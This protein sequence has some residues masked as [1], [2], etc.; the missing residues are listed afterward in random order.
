MSIIS[1]IKIGGRLALGFGIVLLCAGALLALGLWRMSDLQRN[2]EVMVKDTGGGLVDAVEM[3]ETGWAVMQ[4][5]RK[6]MTPTDAMEAERESKRLDELF[7]AYAGW[8][9]DLRKVVTSAEGKA[10]LAATEDD[11]KALVPLVAKLKAMAAEGDYIEGGQMMKNE[12]APL[13]EKWMISLGK[14]ARR[15]QAEM[16]A[17]YDVSLQNYRQTRAGMLGVGMLTLALGAAVAWFITRTIIGPLRHASRIADVIAGGDLTEKIEATSRDE[18]GQLVGSLKTMQ[19]NLVGT[20]NRIKQGTEVISVAAHQIASGNADLSARTE[21]QAGSLEETAA[22]MEELTATVRKNA[23]NAQQANQLVAAAAGLALKG[24]KVVGRVVDTMASI[25]ES[26]RKIVDIIGVIDGI[27]FQTNILALNAAVEAARAG[28]QGR[29]FAVV[30][31]EVRNLAQRSAGAAREIK[32]LIGDSVEKVDLG[33]G[34]VDE[35]GK[36]M[37][38]IVASVQDVT[39]IMGKIAA[40]SEEQSGGI[41]EVNQAIARI[42]DMTQ[43]NA[44]LVEQAAAAAMSMQHQTE[45]L[46]QAVS[47]FRL[48]GSAEAEMAVHEQVPAVMALLGKPMSG[49]LL[50][51]P[52]S[53]A[54]RLGFLQR[55]G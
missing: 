10:L 24:G 11:S 44:A 28:E 25:K 55:T 40:A 13:H 16:T 45:G 23:E 48:A 6:V 18:A 9:A 8:E 35:A 53:L 27:A 4:A 21:S 50:A 54:A 46:M 38:E 22:S 5:L 12:F 41:A 37:T 42:D 33:G 29:G 47:Q 34:L 20:V 52:K 36:T 7:A 17:T 51:A 3:R 15:Q 2:A 49:E 14:L 1:N 19:T 26:S 30:A 39:G 31:A 32:A 43:Q